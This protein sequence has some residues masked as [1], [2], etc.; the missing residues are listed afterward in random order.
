MSSSDPAAFEPNSARPTSAI[1]RSLAFDG[2]RRRRDETALLH[3]L[4]NAIR[5]GLPRKAPELALKQSFGQAMVGLA[6][7]KGVLLRVRQEGSL[8]VEILCATGFSPQDEAAC[9][10]LRPSHDIAPTLIRQAIENAQA[11]LIENSSAAGLDAMQ[12][13]H[14]R[15]LS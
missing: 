3:C 2:P 12:S 6:A 11:R 9:C 5:I 4:T 15:P 14:S 13:L 7:E 1:Q 10:E 8:D